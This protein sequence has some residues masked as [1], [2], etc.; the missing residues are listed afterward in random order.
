MLLSQ[1]DTDDPPRPTTEERTLLEQLGNRLDRVWHHA[2]TDGGLKQQVV[3]LLIDHV[4]AE[5]IEDK[6]EVVL[7][8]KWT[9]GHHTELRS[10]R[11]RTRGR[12]L[13][14]HIVGSA[15]AVGPNLRRARL[16]R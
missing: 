5:L 8:L 1:F 9:S 6:D 15:R 12:A 16:R 7:W 13:T 4:S 10:L 14:R 2:S 3:R 11:R